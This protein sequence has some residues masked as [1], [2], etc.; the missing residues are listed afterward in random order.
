ME[1]D[2]AIRVALVRKPRGESVPSPFWPKVW[3]HLR[4][5]L[6]GIFVYGIVGLSILVMIVGWRVFFSK[7]V[8][9]I[10]PFSVPV[11]GDAPIGLS[12]KSAANLLLDKV[13]EL[14]NEA[15]E[16]GQRATA[17]FLNTERHEEAPDVK[18]EVAGL[19]VEG[20]LAALS[21]VLEKQQ[22]VTG[23]LYWVKE[24]V[25][26][27]AR[28]ENDVWT[29]GPFPATAVELDKQYRMLARNLLSASPS[30]MR[31][32][33]LWGLSKDVAAQYAGKMVHIKGLFDDGNHEVQVASIGPA[34]SPIPQ[35]QNRDQ[36]AWNE[37]PIR[38]K[39]WVS[40]DKCGAKGANDKAEACTKKC[41]A[42]GAKMVIVTDK[43]QKILLVDNPDVLKG[44]EGHHIAV[45]GHVMGDSIHVESA[46]ML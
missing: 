46:K 8:L 17:P 28:L 24:G 18:V 39:G 10:S 13:E 41:L 44:H 12:G 38:V 21:R 40:D 4:E 43:D 34:D 37:N 7:S 23:E 25:I 26:I 16:Y 6:T 35:S 14:S 42:A 27:R 36:V 11:N 32:A 45:S 3:A 15:N 33:R 5:R 29:V 1:D 30:I 31:G 9:V 22:I 19:S 20:V 2:A